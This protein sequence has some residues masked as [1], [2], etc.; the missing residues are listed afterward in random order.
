M[1]QRVLV[2]NIKGPKGDP[3]EA[4][5]Q[6][7]QGIQ[8]P[9]GPQGIPGQDGIQGPAGPQ[10]ERGAEGPAGPNEITNETATTLTGL[11]AGNGRNITFIE[12]DVPGGIA[13]VTSVTS[14]DES[15]AN[16]HLG[17]YLDENGD[18]CQ[19]DNDD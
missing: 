16:Y 8:G 11:L 6:G 1:S 12:V 5:A 15:H 9:Q 2:G 10:G 13:S 17:F 3:G 14:T 18:L 4:G 19:V 7:P